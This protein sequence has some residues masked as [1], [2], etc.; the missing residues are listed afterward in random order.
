MK[1]EESYQ[2]S[3]YRMA[4]SGVKINSYD[5]SVKTWRGVVKLGAAVAKRRW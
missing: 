3:T 5:G 1:I 2:A 4:N